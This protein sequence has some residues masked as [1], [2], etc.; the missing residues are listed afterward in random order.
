MSFQELEARY[1]SG[2]YNKKDI[3]ITYGEG[4]YLYDEQ[5]NRYLDLIAGIAVCSL[6]HAHP[7][8]AGVIAEQA[9]RLISCSEIFYNDQR[10]QLLEE[11]NSIT[12][13]SLNR[14]F[15]C[16]SGTEAMEA[17]LKIAR[18]STKKTDFVA[19][20][21]CFHGRS[22]GALSATHKKD[23]R[24]PFLPLV[25]GFTHV[26]MNNA[27][28]LEEAV[29]GQTAAILIEPIQG[30]GGMRLADAEFLQA[31]RRIADE[32]GCLLIFDEVQCGMGRTGRW[33][34]QEWSGVTPDLM[35]MAKGL[36]SGFPVGA[37]AIGEKAGEMTKGAHGTTFGGNPLACAVATTV[38]RT[39]KH[40]GLVQQAEENGEYLMERLRA[41][42]SPLIR[43]VRGKGLMIGVEL[44]QK[45]GPY[46]QKMFEEHRILMLNAGA[47]VIRIVPP[48][49]IK[50]EQLDYAVEALGQVLSQPVE[51]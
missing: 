29:T 24:D 19:C 12:A 38:I 31:A 22:M 30:E 25:P 42:D 50:R 9:K 26:P 1:T 44:K 43:E 11:L 33:W 46:I 7:H 16:N 2:F 10:A 45:V 3:T 6:G 47:T 13:P 27:E 37:V 23:Y 8:L 4:C 40:R 15:L 51:A 48:L 5:E 35:A 36:G 18:L 34:A 20:N 41:I 17:C 28:K 14:F 32:K 21:M 49:I 39:I